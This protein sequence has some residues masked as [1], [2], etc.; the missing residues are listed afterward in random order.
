MPTFYFVPSLSHPNFDLPPDEAH[1]ATKVIRLS[2]GNNIYCT[3]GQGNVAFCAITNARPNSCSVAIISTE[4]QTPPNPNLTVVVAPPRKPD[5][6]EFMVE[7]LTEIGTTN[8]LLVNTERTKPVKLN[9][10]RLNKIMISAIKQSGRAYLPNIIEI[11]KLEKI[12]DFKPYGTALAG[13]LNQPPLPHIKNNLNGINAQKITIAIGPE[14]DFSPRE[15]EWLLSEG[16]VGIG[17]GPN[18]LRTETAAIVV[19]TLAMHI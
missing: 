10:D 12:S 3:D 13:W 19:A 4:K 17:L 15:I 9:R 7:K 6:L 18:A 11:N 8:I 1:H 2:A 5:R 14:G 16:F